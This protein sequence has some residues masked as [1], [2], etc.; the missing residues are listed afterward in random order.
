MRITANGP[1]KT[2]QWNLLGTF[3]YHKLGGSNGKE[4]FK[5]TPVIN[6]QSYLYVDPTGDWSVGNI[7]F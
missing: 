3:E 6:K 4:I 2:K 5:Q 7:K 1:A